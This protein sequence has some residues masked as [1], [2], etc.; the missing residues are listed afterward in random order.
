[1][2]SALRRLMMI[3]RWILLLACMTARSIAWSAILPIPECEQATQALRIIDAYHQ[4]R[5]AVP[6]RKLHV[7]YFTPADC[8]PAADYEK[9]LSAILQ[10]I[11][12]FYRDNM[13]RL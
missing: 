7:V 9:R 1:M 6:P 3:M 8:E 2:T 12:G 11:R 4:P 10:D 13:Q 5:P